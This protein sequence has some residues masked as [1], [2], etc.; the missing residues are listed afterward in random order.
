MADRKVVAFAVVMICSLSLLA[1]CSSDGG[2]NG[3][4][5]GGHAGAAA[6]AGG[7]GGVAGGGGGGNGG[8]SGSGP[9]GTTG[10]G[11]FDAAVSDV[12]VGAC[13]GLP[14]GELCNSCPPS[15][16]LCPGAIAYCDTNGTCVIGGPPTCP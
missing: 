14:C 9:A 12:G 2:S 10:G 7:N 6:G 15:S 16:P 5:G 11:G 3:D 13:A 1:T 4:G 8:A